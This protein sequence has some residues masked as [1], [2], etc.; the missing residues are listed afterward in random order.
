MTKSDM[1]DGKKLYNLHEKCQKIVLQ[2]LYTAERERE[3]ET[4]QE[5]EREREREGDKKQTVAD[6]QSTASNKMLI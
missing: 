3:R 4:E 6:I 2:M 5:R 1:C